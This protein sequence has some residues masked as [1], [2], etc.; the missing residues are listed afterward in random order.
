MIEEIEIHSVNEYI[1]RIEEITDE[2]KPNYKM[3]YRGQNANYS[4][5]PGVFR[6]KKNMEY[7]ENFII[8]A[9][10]GAYENYCEHI[11]TEAEKFSFMQ[12]YGIPTRLLD[13]TESALIAL[14]FAV[15]E[16]NEK[17]DYTVWVL[18]P[19]KL[20]ELTIERKHNGPFSFENDFIEKRFRAI[21]YDGVSEKL[22]PNELQGMIEKSNFPIAFH[23]KY[24]KNNRIAAQKGMFVMWGINHQSLEIIMG[25]IP[26]SL[27]KIVIK[28]CDRG[29]IYKE[30]NIL[31]ITETTVYPDIKG[32]AEELKS[33]AYMSDCNI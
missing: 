2:S 21:P 28:N 20:N 22:Y 27:Y 4:L 32:L 24:S 16:E 25:E 29:K 17:D 1:T 12:H 15:N 33:S 14:F 3:W 13:W 7:K 23:P 10:N 9:F 19:E 30:L 6:R 18:N 31:G 8:R 26:N 5:L 11:S